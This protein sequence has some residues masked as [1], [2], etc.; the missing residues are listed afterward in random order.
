MNSG[1]KLCCS[2]R[3]TN[4]KKHVIQQTMTILSL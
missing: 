4:A 2:D 1:N 3:I